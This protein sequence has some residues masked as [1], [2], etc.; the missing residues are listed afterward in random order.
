MFVLLILVICFLYNNSSYNFF[1]HSLFYL[2]DFS[3]EKIYKYSESE[4]KVENGKN[5]NKN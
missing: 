4:S 2:Q 1:L 5:K 3:D